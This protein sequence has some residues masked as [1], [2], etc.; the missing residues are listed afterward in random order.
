MKRHIGDVWEDRVSKYI[1]TPDGI[2]QFDIDDKEDIREY[3]QE[4]RKVTS[5][6]KNGF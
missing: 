3:F 1:C 6:L 4:I 2:K 5:F